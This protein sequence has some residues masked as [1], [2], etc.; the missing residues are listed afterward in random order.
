MIVQA[1]LSWGNGAWKMVVAS[2]IRK[3][4]KRFRH[5]IYTVLRVR[6]FSQDYSLC[7][8]SVPASS[9]ELHGHCT[10]SPI[11]LLPQDRGHAPPRL[12]QKHAWTLSMI[13]AAA[14]LAT[15]EVPPA[16]LA[17]SLPRVLAS[18]LAA[19][20]RRRP[21]LGTDM[22]LLQPTHTPRVSSTRS[23]NPT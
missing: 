7:L 14:L 1:V 3:Q 4:S 23:S 20:A 13:A 17:P 9:L 19:W 18:T 16:R 21:L 12:C 2:I 10:H 22:P 11:S 15:V 5:I 8:F 6:K